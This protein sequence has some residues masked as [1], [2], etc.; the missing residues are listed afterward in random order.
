MGRVRIPYYIVKDGRGYWNP[1]AAMKRAGF[2]SVPCGLDGP[3]AWRIAGLWAE[4]WEAERI[5]QG[6]QTPHWPAGSLGEGFVRFKATDTWKRKAAG[7]KREWEGM[8]TLYIAPIFGASPPTEATFDDLDAWYSKLLADKSI[9]TAHRAVKIWR[10]LWRVVAA[11]NYCERERDPSLGIRRKTPTPRNQIW[12]EGEA[13]RLIKGAWRKDYEGLAVLL[14]IAWDTQFAPVDCRRLTPQQTIK[15]DVG[16][17]FTVDRAKTGAPAIGTLGPRSQQ[18]FAAYVAT[19]GIDLLPA[20]PI[21]RNRSG[22][23]YSKETLNKDFAKIRR[24][25]F[26]KGETRRMMDFR[27]SGAVEAMAGKVDGAALAA[28]MANTINQSRELQRTYLP[29][30]MASVTRADEARLRGRNR[31]RFGTNGGEKSE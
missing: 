16:V 21:V 26:G 1:T 17:K 22:R 3:E 25:V 24:F 10:A 31:L 30:D 5:G 14:A 13:V 12:T 27:R 8:W 9:A 7:T 28:K 15:T 4:R 11:M 18:L 23:R 19:L 6:Q 29:V 2:C 20:V